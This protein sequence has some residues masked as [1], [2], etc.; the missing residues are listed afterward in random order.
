MAW[1]QQHGIVQLVLKSNLHQ[2]QYADQVLP[3]VA[4]CLSA[5]HLGAAALP[6]SSRCCFKHVVLKAFRVGLH[7]SDA[8]ESLYPMQAQRVLSMLLQHDALSEEAIAFL[9]QLTEGKS[10][11]CACVPVPSS[12]AH[13]V[14]TWEHLYSSFCS[15]LAAFAPRCRWL[16]I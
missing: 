8:D 6:A 12:Q 16:D 1:L 14:W 9:W 2:A 13:D 15:F 10:D 11:C 3:G 7:A 5:P 4:A